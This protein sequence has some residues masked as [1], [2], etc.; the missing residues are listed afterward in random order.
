LDFLNKALRF[1]SVVSLVQLKLLSLLSLR[2]Q[3]LKLR[4]SSASSG[5]KAAVT[6]MI[7]SRG[8]IHWMPFGAGQSFGRHVKLLAFSTTPSAQDSDAKLGE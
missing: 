8:S 6:L 3:L 2:L 1:I 4:R 7:T 5:T